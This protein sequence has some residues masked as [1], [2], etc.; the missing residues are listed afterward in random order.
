[1]VA[2]LLG[3]VFLYIMRITVHL[4]GVTLIFGFLPGQLDSEGPS[5]AVCSQLSFS[6]P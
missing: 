4:L 2:C 6:F 3:F 1:M 5:A